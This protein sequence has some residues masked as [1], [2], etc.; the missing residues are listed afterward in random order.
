MKEKQHMLIK[1]DRQTMITVIVIIIDWMC[2]FQHKKATGST[3]VGWMI[4][5]PGKTPHV[6]AVERSSLLV[7][8]WSS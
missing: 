4:S 2:T 1:T 7:Y 5:L 3:T 8:E 6:T